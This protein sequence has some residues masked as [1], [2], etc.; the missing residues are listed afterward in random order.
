MTSLTAG[1]LG[2]S[3]PSAA[4]KFPQGL[5]SSLVGELFLPSMPR[6][7]G[8][9]LGTQAGQFLLW[10]SLQIPD[11]KLVAQ[12]WP[13]AILLLKSAANIYCRE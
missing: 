8:C 2:F 7:C 12:T 3:L 1:V 9:V 10:I 5:F 6:E 11:W 4:N 13:A